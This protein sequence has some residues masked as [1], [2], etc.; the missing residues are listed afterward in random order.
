M[1]TQVQIRQVASVSRALQIIELLISHPKHELGVSEIARE[2]GVVKSTAHQLLAT[3]AAH[4]FVENNGT[5]G[6]YC[7]GVR[8]MEAGAVASTQVGLGPA[9]VPLLEALVGE[10]HETCSIGVLVGNSVS[11]VQRVEAESVL[12]VDL[13]VGTRLPIET[14]AVGRAILA[15][16][17]EERRVQILDAL[18]LS[19]TERRQTDKAIESARHEGCAIVRNIPV[20]GISAIAVAVRTSAQAPL[21]G[22]VVAAP[23]FRFNPD[24]FRGALA[25]TA[26]LIAARAERRPR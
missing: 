3:L 8:A 20:D 1:N 17:P 12:R 19:K 23:T 26:S 15:A 2:I 9:V 14:S 5:S 18:D 11:L 21:A 22:L 13:R 24:A 16:M 10:V 6:R 25:R 7:L 4:G